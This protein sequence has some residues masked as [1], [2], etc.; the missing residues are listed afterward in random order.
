MSPSSAGSRMYCRGDMGRMGRMSWLCLAV[1][2]CGAGA[3]VSE[4]SSPEAEPSP[5]LPAQCAEAPFAIA[6]ELEFV[7]ET[8]RFVGGAG[9]VLDAAAATLRQNPSIG[10]VEIRGHLTSAEFAEAPQLGLQRAWIVREELIGRGI[11]ATRL[12]LVSV[13]DHCPQPEGHPVGAERVDFR[14]LIVDGEA[15]AHDDECARPRCVDSSP[16]G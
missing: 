16:V 14:Y 10:S 1:V 15:V 2:G 12:R 6:D 8:A 11:V 5:P 3:V 4:P 13:A 9:S 7:G